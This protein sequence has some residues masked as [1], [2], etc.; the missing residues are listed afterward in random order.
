MKEF[1]QY[2]DPA[3][4]K[5]MIMFSQTTLHIL[6]ILI[7]AVVALRAAG[8]LIRFVQ[9]FLLGRVD[10]NMEELKRIETLGRV[11]R[12][13]AS[14]VIT[15]V[16]G[17]LIL[18]ELGISIAPILAAAGVLGVAVGFGAQSLVK[19]YF[20]GFFLLLENQIRQGD[21]VE[22]GGKGGFVEEVTLRYIKLRDY[23]GN[24]HFI[25]NGTI[26][27]V[28]NMS[29]QFAFSVIDIRISY[30]EN[31][32][33]V[34]ALM[35]QVA[36]DIR[37][38]SPVSHRI[39]GDLEMAGVDA[40]GESAVVI[41]CRFQ[42]EPLAQWDVRREYFKRIKQAFEENG[43]EIPYPQIALNRARKRAE[44]AEKEQEPAPVFRPER[45]FGPPPL[46]DTG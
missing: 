12:Y 1:L 41:R 37:A 2:F 31:I 33:K 17:T 27:T 45:G 19:D 46:G 15:I 10:N 22:A 25:P 18:S 32:D 11:I 38:D 39:L 23:D 29:R 6:L 3:A 24:V 14:V 36:K 28:T 44:D 7:I 8:K 20:S 5:E 4:L 42:V 9:A 43:I 40:L 13:V 26:T 30:K 21:V 34:I 16:T 35:Q